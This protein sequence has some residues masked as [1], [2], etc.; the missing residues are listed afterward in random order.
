V[1]KQ[2]R[3]ELH[4][5]THTRPWSQPV[6]KLTFFRCLLYHYLQIGPLFLFICILISVLWHCW[7]GVR[8]SI[9]PVK[10]SDD[11]LVWL[12]VWSEEQIVCIRSS[13]CHCHPKTPSYLASFKSRLVLPF[14]YQLTQVVLV[15]VVVVVV[16]YIHNCRPFCLWFVRI[17]S[18]RSLKYSL[19]QFP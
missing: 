14:W 16:T 11:V 6:S 19:V 12:S 1:C 18:A 13:W 3:I 9:R 2:G 4:F 15:V 8:K 10:L 17:K 5:S 7:L